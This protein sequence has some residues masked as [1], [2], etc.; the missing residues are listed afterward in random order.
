M[1]KPLSERELIQLQIQAYDFYASLID[2]AVGHGAG[3]RM[4]RWDET[5]A[6]EYR[7]LADQLRQ[8]LAELEAQHP[9]ELAKP[10]TV[11]QPTKIER[12]PEDAG[13]EGDITA[14]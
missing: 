7:Q 4:P 10:A 9:E 14:C 1:A 12:L 6:L 8:R 5:R 11:E 13:G 3:P 2:R